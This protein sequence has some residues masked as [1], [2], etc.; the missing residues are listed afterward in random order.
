M[1][2]LLLPLLT[3]LLTA[4]S[5]AQPA[6]D[7]SPGT[8]TWDACAFSE[9]GDACR[10]AVFYHWQNGHI[11]QE[12]VTRD[13]ESMKA[14]GIGTFY[15]FNTAEGVPAGPVPYMSEEWW[16][17]YRFIGREAKRLGLEMGIMNGGGWGVSG[18]PWVKPEDA[19]QEVAWTETTLRGPARFAGTLQEPLPCLGL[20]R[21]F[22]RDPVKNRRYFVPRERLAGYFCDIVTLAFP[23]SAQVL[24]PE[25]MLD[26][27]DRLDAQG[28]LAWD[29]P[30]GEWTVLRIGYQPT[31]KQ[32]HPAPEGGRGLEV[33]KMSARALD[34]YWDASVARL[35]K[36]GPAV[37]KILIDSYEAGKQNWTPGFEKAFLER[38]GYDPRPFLPALTGRVVES[39]RE[40]ER[41]LW[42][43]R[44]VGSDLIQE[45]FYTHFAELCHQNG[46]QLAVEPYGQFGDIDQFSNGEAADILA[47][48]FLVGGNPRSFT[49]ATVKL[50]SSL[51]HLYGKSI[52]GAEAFTNNGHL[53]DISP[54]SLKALGDLY[55]CQGMN[56]V[57][58][59]SYVHDPYEKWPGLTLGTYGGA[60]N[61]RNTWWADSKGWFDYLARCHYMLRQGKSRNDILYYMGE[62]APARPS[63]RTGLTPQVPEGYDYDFCGGSG[64]LTRL[65]FENGRIVAPSGSE[66]KLLVVRSQPF[67][68]TR[69]LRQLLAL[70]EKGA[71]ICLE[72]PQGTPGRGV[73]EEDMQEIR[74]KL[75]ARCRFGALSDILQ[76]VGARPDVEMSK[77]CSLV[78]THRYADG[79]DIFF[80]SNQELQMSVEADVVF[81]IEGRIPE[82]WNPLDGSVREAGSYCATED[83]RTR[84]HLSLDA[85]GSV[86]VVFRREG[87]VPVNRAPSALPQAD[88]LS[89]NG[90]WQVTLLPGL[91]GEGT[92]F[93]TRQ[94]FNLSDSADPRIRYHSGEIRYTNTFTLSA[95]LQGPVILHLGRVS[96]L[97]RVRING[98][99][100]G[101]LWC[102][103]FCMDITPYAKEGEN[104]VEVEVVNLLFN[105][106]AGD[107]TMAE[108]CEWTTETGSTAAGLSLYRIPDWVKEGRESPTGRHT[109]VS[110]RWPSLQEKA[111]PP[112]GLLGPVCIVLNK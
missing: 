50:A 45:N 72:A 31:G 19:M 60:F 8:G 53:F 39:E 22:Q 13:L 57:W 27:S 9:P 7:A 84:V 73:G 104:E 80:L 78:Y 105:R 30:E 88:T 102:E 11:G 24:R 34:Q 90:P 92:S 65:R 52:V 91:S 40:S 64:I 15:L 42:D 38:M 36:E 4:A 74:Q 82:F 54:S 79:E 110:W 103:P 25:E 18:G 35:L 47:G 71:V 106:L 108:D 32:N 111:L 17:L 94:L 6:T 75:S 28:N 12:A 83:G 51:S 46:V 61:R 14:L 99:A 20:E 77:E 96:V 5:C 16:K 100:A 48:E 37:S 67:L 23:S 41:F 43:F 95:P 101:T 29:V 59:H 93:A 89:L 26:L 112:S 81:D 87:D 58:L 69:V 44:K 63:P 33:D 2:R 55:F 21:D 98:R 1:P 10:T 97:A 76:E 109:F 70:A 86:F 107:L 66:Y 85:G 49:L 68:R 62:D 56:Q 3:L